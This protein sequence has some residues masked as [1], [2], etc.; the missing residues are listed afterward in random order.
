MPTKCPRGSRRDKKSSKCVVTP[1]KSKTKVKTVRPRKPKTTVSDFPSVS[2]IV[3][4]K[5]K[6]PLP[7]FIPVNIKPET[8]LPSF[9]PP[10]RGFFNRTLG[11]KNR[12]QVSY[13]KAKE[14]LQSTFDALNN[15]TKLKNPKRAIMPMFPIESENSIER[16][17]LRAEHYF[18]TKGSRG[19][20]K[21]SERMPPTTLLDFSGGYWSVID[22]LVFQIMHLAI[23]M[24][25]DAQQHRGFFGSEVVT[26]WKGLHVPVGY[27][28]KAIKQIPVAQYL[29]THYR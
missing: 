24:V 2:P 16:F 20:Q 15:T 10:H 28:H 12:A 8:P 21:L 14:Q 6:T 1:K 7:S 3:D 29:N 11:R 13:L 18:D 19:I 27:I 4:I 26:F 17:A 22:S 5:P 25:R 23:E 9:T